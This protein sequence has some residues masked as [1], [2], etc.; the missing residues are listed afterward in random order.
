MK[1]VETN[2]PIHTIFF[3]S[4]PKLNVLSH[5]ESQIKHTKREEII[6]EEDKK[7]ESEKMNFDLFSS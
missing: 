7:D 3:T 1:N 2:Q 5:F 6:L 4:K